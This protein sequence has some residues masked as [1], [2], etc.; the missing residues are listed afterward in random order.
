MIECEGDVLIMTFSLDAHAVRAKGG[1]F[2]VDVEHFDGSDENMAA[3]RLPPQYGR[4]EPN[5]RGP[6]NWCSL[7][8]PGAVAGDTH[9]RM[10]AML[11]IPLIDRRQTA[12]LD[13]LLQ[14]SEAYA[15]K[16]DW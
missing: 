10:P 6:S 5:H 1:R 16:L 8:I 11:G 13:E 4:K 2:D 7:V 12:L 3:V 14:L 15:L 9:A